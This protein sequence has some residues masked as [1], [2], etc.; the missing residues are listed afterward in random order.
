MGKMRKKAHLF[1]PV[2]LQEANI[3][4]GHGIRGRT[5]SSEKNKEKEVKEQSKK[6]QK[7]Q[8]KKGQKRQSKKKVLETLETVFPEEKAIF[9]FCF[10]LPRPLMGKRYKI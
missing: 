7:R 3:Y 5:L 10:P 4:S 9:S 1:R 2:T 6:D 8:S